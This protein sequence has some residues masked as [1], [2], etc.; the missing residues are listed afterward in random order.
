MSGFFGLN[1]AQI[2]LASGFPGPTDLGHLPESVLLLA[3]LTEQVSLVRATETINFHLAAKGG[4]DPVRSN[5]SIFGWLVQ[6]AP[7]AIQAPD[8]YLPG[9]RGQTFQVLK[10]VSP[11]PKYP[12]LTFIRV[13]IKFVSSTKSA[14]GT[15]ELWV[16]T[17]VLHTEESAAA[18]GSKG[19]KVAA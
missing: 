16:S 4:A 6:V 10:R 11:Q 7:L 13:P 1:A 5:T 12:S 19:R 3:S 15:P 8:F 2:I 17:L 9:S 14:S 18:L